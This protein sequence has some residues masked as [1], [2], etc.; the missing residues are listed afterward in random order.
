VILSHAGRV[1][2]LLVEILQSAF[3]GHALFGGFLGAMVAGFRRAAF[4]N[5][6]GIGS[7]AIAHSAAKT[8]QPVRE[9]FVALLEPFIDTIVICSMTALVILITRPE[10]TSLQRLRAAQEMQLQA[11]HTLDKLAAQRRAIPASE[12]T[13]RAAMLTLEK[14]AETT[15]QHA[16]KYTK[17][18]LR[19]T[20]ITSRAFE[21]VFPWFSWILAL[22]VFLFAFST[23]ISWSYYGEKGWEFLFGDG[24]ILLYRLLFLGAVILGCVA[25]LGAV[26]DFSDMMILLCALPNMIGLVLM[27]DEIKSRVEN[28]WKRLKNNEF[29]RYK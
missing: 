19:G 24:S 6:A 7:A 23:M 15:L 26:I 12:K 2:A 14:N 20:E 9:G 1:P 28:Y 16:A 5:E 3:Q 25:N 17:T 18:L 11:K 27:Q 13:K 21:S 22:S 4:S 8:D 29:Q 10:N